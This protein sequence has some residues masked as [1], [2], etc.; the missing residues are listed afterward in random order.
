MPLKDFLFTSE[1]VSEG[2]PD[3]MCDQ[4]SDA[5]LDALLTEDP[6]SRVALETLAK[7]GLIVLAGEITSRGK[8]DYVKIA[9]QTA[10]DIGYNSS[11]VG[12]DGN[13][14]AVLTAIEP[15]SAD[16]SQG[17][18]EGEGLHKEQG[19]GDQGLMFGFACDETPEIM[20]LP[21]AMAHRLMENLTKLRKSKQ[22]GFLRPD[23]KSQVTVRYVDSRPVEVTAVVVSTQHSPDVKYET[24]R[25]SI[26]EELIKKT[27][28]AQYLTRSTIYHVNPTGSFIIGGPHGDCGLT[29]RKIIVDTYGGYGRH[30]GGAF[31]GKDPSKVD[32]SACYMARH[33]AKNVV[34]AGLATKC[35][36]QVAYAIGVAEPVSL[37]VDTFDTGIVPENKLSATLR[38]LFDFRPAGI[39]KTLNL[40]RPIYQPTAAYGHFGR[41]PHDGLFPWERTDMA[42]TLRN[43]FGLNGRG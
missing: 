18:T 32:R 10:L 22:L 28:P 43:A 24:I 20:P 14:C 26:I 38:E 1:S 2:H 41:N 8:P 40:K 29:G 36:I 15:Q 17:V 25:E 34:A 30:G 42:E 12:F 6:N 5:V 33:V 27:I 19:A 31:S 23:A 13:M 11:E 3:K 21:I 7:T 16:I 4:I 37:L 39:I 35:E 9:R